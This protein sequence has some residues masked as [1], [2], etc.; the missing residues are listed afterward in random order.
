[1]IEAK[2]FQ[3][4]AFFNER[5]KFGKTGSSELVYMILRAAERLPNAFSAYSLRAKFSAYK[6]TMPMATALRIFCL[7]S[8]ALNGIYKK[9]YGI[10]RQ[11][12]C[13]QKY[14]AYGHCA[15]RFLHTG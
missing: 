11:I 8:R 10:A 14:N 9:S 4:F 7:L 3:T 5:Q 12:F 15:T 6:N 13:L 1:L 2:F